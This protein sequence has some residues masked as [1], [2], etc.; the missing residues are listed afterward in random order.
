ML[1]S[2][3]YH[4]LFLDKLGYQTRGWKANRSRFS[5]KDL[6]ARCWADEAICVVYAELC[7]NQKF[8]ESLQIPR[9]ELSWNRVACR[10]HC[11][12]LY[13]QQQRLVWNAGESVHCSS[14]WHLHRRN[15]QRWVADKEDANIFSD[16]VPIIAIARRRRP[17]V[18]DDPFCIGPD[19][20]SFPSGHASRSSL[21]LG[22]FIFL[23]PFSFLFWP[24]ICAWWLVIC[25][26]RWVQHEHWCILDICLTIF[27]THSD[28][29]YSV[30][31]SSMFLEVWFLDSLRLFWWAW[32]G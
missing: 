22:F 28:Y 14:H 15:Y 17:S 16:I 8:Q 18:N 19:V 31:T 25:V 29:F 4:N 12:Y 20:Y 5:E 26:S 11:L 13:V 7:P 30:T 32:S 10:P 23:Y 21:L 9:V 3:V 2:Y 24:A 1:Y 6:E 27:S